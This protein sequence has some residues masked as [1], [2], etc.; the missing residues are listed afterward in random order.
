MSPLYQS[1]RQVIIL[2]A[3]FPS[4]VQR[5]QTN[6]IAV[7]IKNRQIFDINFCFKIQRDATSSNSSFFCT[8]IYHWPFDSIFRVS[9]HFLI[10]YSPIKNPI[11]PADG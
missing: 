3:L 2:C 1:W 11:H 7:N 10:K 8:S 9:R 6:K 5:N 4:E